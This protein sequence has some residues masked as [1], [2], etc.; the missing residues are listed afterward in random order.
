MHTGGLRGL[1]KSTWF[2]LKSPAGVVCIVLVDSVRMDLSHQT[3]FLDAGLL[4][5]QVNGG[6]AYL[7]PLLDSLSGKPVQISVNED[8]SVFWRH[9]LPTFAGS[10]RSW[11]HKDT[12]PISTEHGKPFVCSCGSGVFSETYLASL[13]QFKTVANLAVRVAVPVI[14]A[15]PIS[16]DD[17]GLVDAKTAS[18][19]AHHAPPTARTQATQPEKEGC[20]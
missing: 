1:A 4:L 20:F 14:F 3:V 10:C 16:K 2:S 15:S 12:W 8:Q 6:C 7:E 9:L 13:Q 11:D 18:A 5:P 17:A 19:R